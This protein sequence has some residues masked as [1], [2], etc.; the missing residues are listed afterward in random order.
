MNRA[1]AGFGVTICML[2]L[3][4]CAVAAQWSEDQTAV[5]QLNSMTPLQ[6][7]ALIKHAQEGKAS[8]QALLGVAYMV[9]V[10]VPKDDTLAMHWFLK[11]ARKKEPIALNN[12]GLLYFHG[13]GTKP[14]YVEAAKFFRAASAEGNSSAQFNLA[15]MYHH[16]FGVPADSVEA[17][18]WYEIAARLGNAQAQNSLA[19]FYEMGLGVNKDTAQAESW[20]IKAAE[21]GYVH[22]EFNLG[23]FYMTPQ[24]HA[25]A[26]KW[27]LAAAN[28]GHAKA[29]HP[30][31]DIYLHGHCMPVNYREAY[32]W[33]RK[34]SADDEWTQSR[35]AECRKHL[36][37]ADLQELDTRASLDV[38]QGQ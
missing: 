32:R 13:R 37:A 18:K 38:K 1:R 30:V 26:L 4:G 23:G 16:G 8:A 25:A 15:L 33:A 35:L 21:Q 3:A 29:F 20:Y 14:D 9:G 24:N 28:H 19:Y 12:L 34:M 36:S 6:L 22:A 27:F 5:E 10:R 7:Q 17:A 31:V 2:L 11:A